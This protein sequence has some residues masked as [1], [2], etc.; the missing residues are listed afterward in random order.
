MNPHPA[1]R[2][3]KLA[4]GAEGAPLLVIDQLLAEP[5]RLVEAAARTEFADQGSM[6]PGLRAAAPLSYRSLLESV[7]NPL[8]RDCFGLA[9][10]RFDF[11][12]CHYSLVAQPPAQLRFLQRVPHID[13][14]GADGLATVHY[15]FHGDWGGTAFY[16]HRSTGFE[17]VAAARGETYFRELERESHGDAAARAGYIDGDT[18]LFE[19][20][21]SVD[22]AYNRLI[23]YRRNCLHSGNIDST[24]VPPADPLT[25]R[26][27]IN[28]FID[29][30][31]AP[32]TSDKEEN[33]NAT[34]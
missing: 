21:A 7:L 19:R 34:A 15:L 14:V 13:S 12:M 27:S 22:A 3:N 17:S 5:E 32:D 11:P 8:L 6:F 1:M 16:R 2:I 30:A 10:G 24:R 29:V 9:P 28:S 23:V 4:L 20:I 31:T 18:A 25:G 26:L 33:G